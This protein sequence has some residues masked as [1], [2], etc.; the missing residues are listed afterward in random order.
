M[1]INLPKSKSEK[2]VGRIIFILTILAIIAL[3]FLNKQN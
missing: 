1:K 3:I 2:I